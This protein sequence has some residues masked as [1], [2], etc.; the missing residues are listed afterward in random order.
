MQSPIKGEPEV[1][2]ETKAMVPGDEETTLPPLKSEDS[3]I[4]LSASSPELSEHLQLPPVSPQRD[5]IWKKGG[6]MQHT[7]LSIQELIASFASKNI[8]GAQLTTSGEESRSKE[9]TEKQ[10]KSGAQRPG[11]S[12]P[13]K[14]DLW[15][16]R[17][18]TMPQFKQMLSDLFTTRGS[19]FRTRSSESHSSLPSSPSRKKQGDWDTEQVVVSLAGSRDECREAFAAA[20]HLLLDCA[21][22]PV[23]LSQEEMEQ[24]YETLFQLPGERVPVVT[25]AQEGTWQA[26]ELRAQ[27]VGD[28]PFRL[29]PILGSP[30][31]CCDVGNLLGT[32]AF[33]REGRL[34][35]GATF[36]S[37][38]IFQ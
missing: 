12:H 29:A 25:P 13:D 24:L 33:W 27:H 8:F 1:I 10:E 30:G 32:P 4:G 36:V 14:K 5:D 26:H 21:T 18:I 23:Y 17:P 22:F 11:A 6:T 19:P 31:N 35:V 9:S 16:A 15:E 2:L 3:G 38:L 34:P 37:I 28:R 7:F 20:C